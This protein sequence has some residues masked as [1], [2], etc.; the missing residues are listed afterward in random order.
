MIWQLGGA[1]AAVGGARLG[2]VVAWHLHGPLV[3]SHARHVSVSRPITSQSLGMLDNCVAV[4]SGSEY[5]HV[6]TPVRV[7]LD[8]STMPNKH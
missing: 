8:N 7:S 6:L 3:N 5:I 2:M 4:A 1:W